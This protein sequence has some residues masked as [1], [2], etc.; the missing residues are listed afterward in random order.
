M[1][2]ISRAFEW[3]M[4]HRVTNHAS[5]CKNPHGHHYRMLV[6]VTGVIDEREGT[7]TQGM[8]VDFGTLKQLIDEAIVDMYDHSFV[9]W[10]KD[11]VMRRFADE[12][13][14]FRMYG[15][16]FVPTAE[17]LVEFFAEEIKRVLQ[18]KLPALRLSGVEL[19]ETPKS[20]ATWSV[21][22]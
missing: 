6:S 14:D 7:T 16:S 1:I 17:R 20:S 22:A 8:V 15:L 9:Y 10:S 11:D 4:G 2:N 19:F 13:P 21:E 18:K 3:D 5:L 12:N